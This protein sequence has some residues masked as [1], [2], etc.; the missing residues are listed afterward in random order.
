M[1]TESY[2]GYKKLSKKVDSLLAVIG[3]LLDNNRP[4]C[5]IYEIATYALIIITILFILFIDS[6]IV[7]IAYSIVFG[8]NVCVIIIRALELRRITKIFKQIDKLQ[9]EQEL[10]LACGIIGEPGPDMIDS[11]RYTINSTKPK[12]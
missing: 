8:F 7:Q 4:S 10:M 12:I 9:K 11:L 5:R 2:Q 6:Y 3:E 1:T